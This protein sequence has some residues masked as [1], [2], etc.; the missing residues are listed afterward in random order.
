[1][2]VVKRLMRSEGLAVAK[3][4]S[5]LD[6]L[7]IL[8]KHIFP[9]MSEDQVDRILQLRCTGT[10]DEMSNIPDAVIEDCFDKDDQELAKDR[11][12]AAAKYQ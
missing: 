6:C 11:R 12:G 10:H 4:A 2:T 5:D 8:L 3:G 1:M 9:K 7:V